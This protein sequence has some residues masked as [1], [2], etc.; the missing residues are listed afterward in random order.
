MKLKLWNYVTN[1]ASTRENLTLH[2]PKRDCSSYLVTE[3]LFLPHNDLISFM[4][5]YIE[6]IV[7]HSAQFTCWNTFKGAIQPIKLHFQLP[8]SDCSSY[9]VTEMLFL[10]HNDLVSFVKVYI[11]KVIVHPIPLTRRNTLKV[12]IHPLKSTLH[13]LRLASFKYYFSTLHLC[14]SGTYLNNIEEALTV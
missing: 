9:L 13:D 6:K 7:G 14:T 3:M 5:V 4:K 8:K 12:A 2:L 11:E 10:P 1:T